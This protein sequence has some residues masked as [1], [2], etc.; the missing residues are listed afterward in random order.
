MIINAQNKKKFFL[1]DKL[2]ESDKR[3]KK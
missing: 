1:V 3:I 2:I